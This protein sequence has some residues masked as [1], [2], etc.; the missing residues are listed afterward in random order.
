MAFVVPCP[1][2]VAPS[3]PNSDTR[4]R[5]V[6]FSRPDSVSSPANRRAARIGP[7]VCELDGPTPMVKRSSAVRMLTMP[8]YLP[9]MKRRL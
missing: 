8:T 6:E 3:E 4:I 9:F 2:P 7:T 5:A 1:T